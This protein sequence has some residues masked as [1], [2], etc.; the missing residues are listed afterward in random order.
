MDKI[1]LG[2]AGAGSVGGW[3]LLH[4]KGVPHVEVAAICDVMPE[5]AGIRASE[6]GISKA[7]DCVEDMLAESEFDL[8]VNATSMP[9]HFTVNRLALEAGKHVF[10]EKPFAPTYA[11]GRQLVELADAR[12]VRLWAAPTAT[13]SPQYRCMA[14][15]IGSG[16]LGGLLGPAVSVACMEST[17]IP[18]R[19]VDGECIRVETEDNVMVLMEHRGGTLSHVQSG[20]AYGAH[21]H[22]RTIEIIGSKGAVNLLGFDWGPRGVQV[23]T[24]EGRT[25]ETRCTDPEGYTW[26]NG[27]A[28]AASCLLDGEEGALKID[29]A[30]H[31]VEVMEAAHQSAASGTRVAL[32]STF[33]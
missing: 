23:S 31:V 27:A 5:R 15:I 32:E 30:L 9:A 19:V 1:R 3:Y 33:E 25:W 22:D 17:M 10:C 24:D 29:H 18:E 6:F 12:G 7:F 8:L 2:I 14:E 13:L 20:F 4:L 16:T 28:Y 11:Q 21:N 26:E